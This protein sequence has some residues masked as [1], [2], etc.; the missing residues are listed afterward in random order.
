M[1]IPSSR[2][3]SPLGEDMEKLLSGEE[4]PRRTP[5][6]PPRTKPGPK[7]LTPIKNS[8]AKLQ[9]EVEG[10]TGTITHN[11]NNRSLIDDDDDNYKEEIKKSANEYERKLKSSE[12][13]LNFKKQA[14]ALRKKTRD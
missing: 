9:K 1:S 6:T 12:N 13:F 2:S 3:N 11:N 10:L 14:E 7:G 8:Y 4:V 5:E